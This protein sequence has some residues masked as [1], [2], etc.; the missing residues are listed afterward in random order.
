MAGDAVWDPAIVDEE[1]VGRLGLA[2]KAYDYATILTIANTSAHTSLSQVH[3]TLSSFLRWIHRSRRPPYPLRHAD[4]P[5]PLPPQW[6]GNVIIEGE[7]TKEGL[8]DL[9]DNMEKK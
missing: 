3:A 6:V 7:G 1:N 9:L 8:D 4:A 5:C 2:W